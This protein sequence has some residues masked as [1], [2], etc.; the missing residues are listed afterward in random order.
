[1]VASW[2]T[3][4]A[5]TPP[6][7]RSSSASSS[8]S[9]ASRSTRIGDS[10][11]P[12][13]TPRSA[14]R[15]SGSTTPAP[16]SQSPSRGRGDTRGGRRQAPRLHA[17]YRHPVRRRRQA[18]PALRGDVRARHGVG[19]AALRRGASPSDT[20]RGGTMTADEEK[21]I[22]N[23]STKALMEKLSAGGKPVEAVVTVVLFRGGEDS[24]VGVILELSEPP[25]TDEE[26]HYMS[27]RVL[28]AAS[29]LLDTYVHARG[30]CADCNQK[31][32]TVQ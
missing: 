4:P 6:S 9:T 7:A 31:K 21:E 11:T 5:R 14:S 29:D 12:S 17:R 20:D 15:A 26:G 27:G 23:T 18:L 2:S 24:H 1:M 13:S 8:N 30:L 32:G 19:A 22:V 28:L 25:E 10:T 3:S 16:S